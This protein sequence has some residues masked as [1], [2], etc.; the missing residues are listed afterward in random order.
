MANMIFTKVCVAQTIMFDFVPAFKNVD[1]AG[2]RHI[3]ELPSH[4]ALD[5]ILMVHCSYL[6]INVDH[7][8]LS[9]SSVCDYFDEYLVQSY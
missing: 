1:S 2:F 6:R 5:F 7:M 8:F 3:F 9:H 4:F